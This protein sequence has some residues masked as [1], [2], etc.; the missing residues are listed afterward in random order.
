VAR[1]TGGSGSGARGRRGSR[2]VRQGSVG[3]ARLARFVDRLAQGGVGSQGA[4]A[5][6]LA[7]VHGVSCAREAAR[8]AAA[9]PLACGRG[10]AGCLGRGRRRVGQGRAWLARPGFLA[11]G[12]CRQSARVAG[13]ATRRV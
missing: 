13:G 5:P 6:G 10:G 8:R 1:G 3:V 7:V 2:S 12:G 4:A 11:C 9:R